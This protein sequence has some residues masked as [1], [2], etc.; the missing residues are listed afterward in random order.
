MEGAQALVRGNQL[1]HVWAPASSV[2]EATFVADW[3]VSHTTSPIV[4]REDLA[5][6]P[7]VF[8]FWQERH[9]AFVRRYGKVSFDTLRQAV[10][11]GGGWQVIAGKPE[12]GLFKLGHTHPAQSN[13]GLLTLVSMTYEHQAKCRGLQ[14]ADILD[15]GFQTWLGQLERGTLG[16]TN[17]T[18]TMMREMVLK[19]PSAFDVVFVYESVAVEY[20]AS[21][22]GRWGSLTVVYPERNLWNENPYYIV[23]APWSTPAHRQAAAAFLEF[24]LSEPAQ[25]Q[26]MVCGFRPVNLAVALRSAD[27]PFV[28][29]ARY[30]L[31]VDIP[32]SCEPPSAEV[33]NNL[34]AF[35]Q[36]TFSGR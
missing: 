5:L 15:P 11:E 23:D 10:V 26:A 30:G 24:L 21:A 16:L 28:K 33:T 18:G 31:Q 8:V 29:H 20:L 32:S 1:I 14:L 19:G 7:M 22:E 2:Y 27:S 36:R 12:W 9:A 35:W 3:L 4:R 34:L 25:R 6:T 13:S 17:S